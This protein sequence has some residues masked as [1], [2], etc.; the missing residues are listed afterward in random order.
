MAD[1]PVKWTEAPTEIGLPEPEYWT[2]HFDG[3]R[4]IGGSG[5]SVVL[6][7]P[8][9][10]KLSYV[11]QIHFKATNNV[12]EYEALLHGLHIARDLGIDR[13]QCF[14]DSDLVAQQVSSAW[15]AKDPR[16]ALYR[17]TV[18]ELAKCFYGYEVQHIK[19]EE[20]D[21]AD[22]LSRLGSE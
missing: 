3:S 11:L 8:K 12:A 15:E 5:A 18:D 14:G 17:A 9:G 7:S 2:L 19:R 1:F 21:A 22:T 6:R 10:D 4:Q 20:N 16:M 13:I